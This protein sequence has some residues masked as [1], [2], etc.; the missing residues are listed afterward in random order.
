MSAERPSDFSAVVAVAIAF[1]RA[2]S[3]VLHWSEAAAEPVAGHADTFQVVACGFV[4][5][6]V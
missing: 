1:G 3:I 5:C 4:A 6:E 2:F